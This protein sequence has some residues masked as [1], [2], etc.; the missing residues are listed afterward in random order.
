MPPSDLG[1][2]PRPTDP[3]VDPAVDRPVD[4]A[5]RPVRAPV[6][7]PRAV[8]TGADADT[9]AGR[10]RMRRAVALLLMT[11]V[12]PG[13]AQVAAGN[14]T[15]GRI[16]LRT[17]LGLLA[18]VGLVALVGAVWHGV[19]LSLAFSMFSLGVV[20]L[21][22]IGLALGWAALF[23]D[24]WRL[25][26]PRSLRRNQRLAL[27]AVNGLV[28]F[29]VV[30]GLL[31]GAHLVT[32][33]RDLVSA[34]SGDGVATDPTHGRYNV[35]LVGADAGEGRIGMRSD[36]MTLASIDEETGETVLVS[37]PRNLQN[38]PF[39]EGSVLDDE[40]PDG[41]DCDGCYLNGVATWATDHPELF[42]SSREAS[43]DELF[44]LGM[45]ATVSAVEGVT[46]LSVN[47]WAVVDMNGFRDLVDAFGGVEVDVR[48]RI[49]IGGVGAPVTGY[50]EAGEQTLNGYEALW[51]SRS[52]ADS[53]DY[54]RMA[55]QKCMMTALLAQ[56]DPASLVTRFGE[57]AQ[58]GSAMLATSIPA[59]ELDRFA[60]LGIEARN[61][62]V[63][64]VSIVPPAVNTADPDME[65]VHQLIADAVAGSTEREGGATEQ[66]AGGSGGSGGSDGSA[67]DG[68]AEGAQVDAGAAD[69]VVTGGSVGSRDEGYAAN[70][71]EDVS[72]SC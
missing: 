43:E 14:R 10:V 13:S 18:V 19:L 71:S 69:E 45:D 55:R 52:R 64:S 16:V 3:T 66:A 5:G 20:R 70:D 8:R 41:F 67:A 2:P 9:R 1:A 38:F 40:F 12:L 63:S 56:L 24:A 50:I 36:S 28:C 53:D 11:L 59:G 48:G 17:W 68:S 31:F 37:L 4:P 51:F 39:R 7:A 15:L 49:P 65:V 62:P 32:A 60:Q 23:V 47:Y 44:E 27:V 25:A 42:G 21:V 30:G 26:N 54:S 58:A 33:Q 61:H 35:L 29:S 34:I 72:S 57:I 22:L 6:R 46:D